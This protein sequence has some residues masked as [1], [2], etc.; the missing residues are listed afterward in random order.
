[1]PPLTILTIDKRLRASRLLAAVFVGLA[2][3]VGLAAQTL[4]PGDL[5]GDGVVDTLDLVIL[6][7]YLA[8]NLQPGSPPFTA[9]LTAADLNFDGS[10][11][12]VDLVLLNARLVAG[13]RLTIGTSRPRIWWTPERLARAR[14]WYANNPFTPA[15]TDPLGN[16]FRYVLTGES[17]FARRAIAIL[18]DFTIPE[19]RLE[20]VSVD[21]YRWNDWVPIVFDWTYDAMTPAERRTFIDRYDHYT[22][23]VRQKPL[24]GVGYES[25]NYYW[26]YLRNELNWSIATYYESALAETFLNDALLTRWQNSFLPYAATAGRGGVPPEG[27]QYGRYM[28]AYPAVPFTTAALLG[29]DLYRESNFFKEALF[30]LIYATT[31]APT[32]RKGNPGE[33]HQVFPFAD[34]EFDGGYP[35]AT[36]PYYGD[37]MTTMAN[38]YGHSTVGRWARRW[39]SLVDAPV[40]DFVGAVDPGGAEQDFGSLP[41]DYYAS[42]IQYFYTRNR[43]GPQATSILLQLASGDSGHSHLDAGTFQIWRNGRWLSKEST[44]YETRFADGN[45]RQTI[46]HNGLL[47]GGI[48]LANAYQDGPP[49]VLRLESRERYSYAAV[50]LSD[51]Y[52]AHASSDRRRDDNPY[53][54]HALREFVFVKPLETLVIL[55]R[56]ESSGDEIPAEDVIKSFLLHFPERPEI[57]GSNTVVGSNGDQALRLTTLLPRA[58]RYEVIDEGAF[59]GQHDADSYYQYRLQIQDSGQRLSYFLNVLQGRDAS[60]ANVTAS[61]TEDSTAW[62]IRLDHP[63]AGHA[64]IVLNKGSTSTG[65]RVGYS[66]TG[67]PTDLEPLL[68]RVQGIEVTDSGPVWER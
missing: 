32:A 68:N 30:Y 23:V 19:E 51:A 9:P 44:G 12:A 6:A 64:V 31:P 57:Q 33:Y 42:G 41:V 1:M 20:Q 26:G 5:N 66:V 17:G 67:V 37:F 38:E 8:G 53:A 28:L 34:D 46:A 40:S 65:G 45:S 50:D 39:L 63:T 35:A 4:I 18:L 10:V 11:N 56:L 43:W 2:L 3:S 13:P 54:S 52:R 24:G 7:N 22:D 58:P 21:L 59:E 16:A 62:T 48:G 29:R 27:S 47:F 14:I 25:S 61:V 60:G 49:D 36:T 15:A 55:D